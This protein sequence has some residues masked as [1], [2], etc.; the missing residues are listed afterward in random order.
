MNWDVMA[1]IA[2][3]IGAIGVIGT[4]IY[5]AIE[6]RK[7]T[8]AT[9]QQ[10][11]HSI[12]TRRIGIFD[13][14]VQDREMMNIFIMG[15]S[16]GELDELDSNRFFYQMTNFMSHFQDIYMQFL[17]GTIEAK[18]WEAE[19]RMTG[20]VLEQPGFLSWWN[21]AE[22]YFMPEFVEAVARIGPVKLVIFDQE[23]R[24]WGRPGGVWKQGEG[25]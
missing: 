8:T 1:A 11:Y 18:V 9:R 3:V 15:T 10:S 22:Q 20:A 14:F 6:L 17:A 12:A 16:G 25:A 4:L 2:E 7:S 5:L 24:K 21:E 19:R 13:G 23:T